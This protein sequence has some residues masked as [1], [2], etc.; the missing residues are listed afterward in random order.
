MVLNSSNT[1]ASINNPDHTDN[2]QE[3][4]VSLYISKMNLFF[5]DIHMNLIIYP[6]KGPFWN[7]PNPTCQ[8][9]YQHL[10]TGY[11]QDRASSATQQLS[12]E[13]P[14][15]KD[16]SLMVTMWVQKSSLTTAQV[17][18]GQNWGVHVCQSLYN[19]QLLK[20]G[21]R[22]SDN[23]Q[24][25]IWKCNG[26]YCITLSNVS[27]SSRHNKH[28]YV[29]TTAKDGS[30]VGHL[31]FTVK[32]WIVHHAYPFFLKRKHHAMYEWEK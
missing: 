22:Q 20:N 25:K 13:E 2:I 17:E 8:A 16:G 28:R 31:T 30:V 29:V 27:K 1:T 10:I 4:L 6:M 23:I 12:V 18:G 9:G 26:S 14:Y 21:E 11:Y 19:M 5:L 3:Y 32:L 15:H 7:Q 24:T